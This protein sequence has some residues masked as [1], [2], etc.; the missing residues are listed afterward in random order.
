MEKH[1]R[2]KVGFLE[3]KL[4]RSESR[5]RFSSKFGR[6]VSLPPVLFCVYYLEEVILMNMREIGEVD[7][8][9]SKK[10]FTTVSFDN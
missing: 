1:R 2:N 6:N 7:E 9:I 8:E 4:S 5:Y 10:I 3:Q